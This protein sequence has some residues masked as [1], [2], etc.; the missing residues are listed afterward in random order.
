[1]IVLVRVD[2][3]LV[4]GQIM[5]GWVPYHKADS[6]IVASDEAARSSF[7]RRAI[8]SCSHGSLVVKVT[9]AQ[10]AIHD[11]CDGR[12]DTCRVIVLVSGLRDAMRLCEGGINFASINIGNLH[13]GG[14]ARMITKSVYLNREDEEIIDRFIGLGIAI[15]IRAVPYEKVVPYKAGKR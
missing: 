1:M 12:Y 15:E 7:H 6:I 10:E 5:E 4:H 8:E 11:I 3:R 9:E 2:D 13:P 14:D